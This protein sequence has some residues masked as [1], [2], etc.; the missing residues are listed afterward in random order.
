LAAQA[1]VLRIAT[2]NADLSA[3]GPGLL[4]HDLRKE[5]LPPQRAAVVAVIAALDA[6]VLVLTGVDYD[7]R[8]EALA[9]LEQRLAAAGSPY[10]YRLALKPNTGVATGRDLDR[11]GQLGEPRD[12]QGWGR[13]AGEGG[14]AVL[15]RLPIGPDVR[16]FSGFLWAD[17]PGNLMPEDDPARDLQRLHTT[18]A[19]EVPIVLK[20]GNS[21]RLLVFYAS[22][23]VFD[24]PEDRNGR[25]NHDEAA[26]WLRLLEGGLPMPPPAGP[27]V[28]LG[29]TSLD[30]MDGDGRPQALRGLLAHP[31]LQDPQPRGDHGR[32][33]PGQAGDAAL[34]TALYD[35]LGGL[36]VSVILPSADLMVRAAAVLW[37]PD[38]DPMAATRAAA[39]RHSPIWVDLAL[40]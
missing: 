3:P 30:P 11:N 37:P 35:D 17:L 29:Q 13:F 20:G 36:R 34:D 14:I 16:D 6:D 19:Y 33:E 9:A 22:P 39:S 25:R 26:F 2:Y 21:L 32:V 38:S 28:I 7:L 10:P 8:G 18:G 12:A 24:G 23:P 31:T 15:S 5:D 27:F 4:L 1:D 40:P